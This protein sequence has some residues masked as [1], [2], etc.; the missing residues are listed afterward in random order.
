MG[1]TFASARDRLSLD[2][3]DEIEGRR[4][5]GVMATPSRPG[6]GRWRRRIRQADEAS[7]DGP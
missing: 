7:R 3:D 5:S 6:R 2:L 4:E 1:R